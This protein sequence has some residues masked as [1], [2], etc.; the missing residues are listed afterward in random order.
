MNNPN[1]I[2]LFEPLDK[3]RETGGGEFTARCP[4]PNH[5]DNNPSFNGNYY[6]GLWLCRGCGEK[7][8]ASQLAEILGHPNPKIYYDSNNTYT[9]NTYTPYTSTTTPMPKTDLTAKREQYKNNLKANMNKIPSFWDSSLAVGFGIGLTNKGSWTFEYD[10]AIKLHKESPYWNKNGKF[11]PQWYPPHKISDYRRDYELFIL[12]GEKDV[13]TLISNGLQAISGYAGCTSIPRDENKKYILD[14]LK[15]WTAWITICYD[16]IDGVDGANKLAKEILKAHPHLKVRIAQWDKSREK[17][18]DVF[19]SFYNEDGYFQ[20]AVSNAIKIEYN[21]EEKED[22]RKVK[23]F[24]IFKLREFLKQDYNQTD[25]IIDSILYLGQ[26]AV[27]GGDSGTKKSMVAIASAL[28]IASGHPLFEHFKIKKQKV[29]LLQFENENYDMKER[30]KTML[31]YYVDVTGTDDWIDNIQVQELKKEDGHFVDNWKRIEQTIKDFDFNNGV[32]IVDNVYTS[33]DKDI[34]NNLECRQLVAQVNHIRKK[35]KLSMLLIAHCVKNS[36]SVDKELSMKQI[37]GGATLTHNIANVTMLGDS[38]SHT[39]LGLMKIVKGGRSVKNELK[40][41]P[42]KLHWSDE[43]CTFTKGAI[44][45]NETIHFVP[46]SK[47]WEIELLQWV[48]DVEEIKLNTY[49]SREMFVRNLPNEEKEKKTKSGTEFWY[50]N[51]V[52]RFLSKMI[53]WGLVKKCS[54]DQYKMLR[55]HIKDFTKNAKGK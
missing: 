47:S 8:N 44:I 9:S 53:E 14:L 29:L 4:L 46:M 11:K 54:K 34:E 1:Y 16:A 50:P 28:S 30:F 27:I 26:T 33:T 45:P 38:T 3:F 7:G 52:T 43:S 6:N 40:D 24:K 20:D 39:D 31:K 10:G 2:D 36:T 18:Y 25:P 13:F 55:N 19:D 15:D 22:T 21:E 37:Q 35:F 17:G 42:F 41:I 51:R 49:F 5:D 48:A 23:P 12:E 32:L